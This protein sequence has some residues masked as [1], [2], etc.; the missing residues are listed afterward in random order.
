[1]A[2]HSSSEIRVLQNL[3]RQYKKRI[4]TLDTVPGEVLGE[5]DPDI[6]VDNLSLLM[7][8]KVG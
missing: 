1:M 8:N 7:E 6:L 5:A 3:S 4:L 2:V